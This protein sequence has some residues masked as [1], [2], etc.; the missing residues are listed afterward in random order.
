MRDIGDGNVKWTFE[1]FYGDAAIYA[2][3]TKCGF[4]HNVS[5]FKTGSTEIEIDTDRIYNFC[6]TCGEED[7]TEYDDIIDVI[8]NER[9]VNVLYGEDNGKNCT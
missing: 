1:K 9:A 2:I 7:E 8:W 4:M 3:C 6:P 5:H